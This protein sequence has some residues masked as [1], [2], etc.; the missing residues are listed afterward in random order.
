MQAQ[1]VPIVEAS[2]IRQHSIRN[3]KKGVEMPNTVY[4]YV[5][6]D[7]EVGKLKS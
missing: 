7:L 2:I 6:N 3:Y 5:F 4:A 1:G